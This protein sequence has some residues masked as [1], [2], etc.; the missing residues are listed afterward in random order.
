MEGGLFYLDVEGQSQ[1]E[2]REGGV[3]SKGEGREEDCAWYMIE[4]VHKQGQGLN[5]QNRAMTKIPQVA[6]KVG[7]ER[8]IMDSECRRVALCSPPLDR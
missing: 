2:R 6:F 4:R 1:L 5:L 7:G 8:S 3:V